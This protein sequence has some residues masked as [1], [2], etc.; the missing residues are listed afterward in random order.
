ME[1]DYEQLKQL[2]LMKELKRYLSEKLKC[3][4]GENGVDSAHELGILVDKY[5]LT[6]K[7]ARIRLNC[8]DISRGQNAS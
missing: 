3:Y 8:S 6:H 5:T 7:K 1:T 2:I 4:V